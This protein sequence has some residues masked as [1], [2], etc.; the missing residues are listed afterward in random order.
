M[1]TIVVLTER[2]IKIFF[3]D[4]GTLFTSLLAPLILLV[5]FILFLGDVY[6]DSFLSCLP[7]GIAVT[8]KQANGFAGG[9]LISSLLAVCCVSVAFCA[10]MQMVQDK[11][12]GVI[13]D[14]TVAPYKKSAL[15]I[16]YF[17]ATAII[18]IAICYIALC[19]GLIYIAC[20]GWYLS[21][22]QVFSI[23]LDVL[24]LSTFGTAISSVICHFLKSQGGI[25]AVS[26]TVSSV[27]GFI[28][29]AY[30]PISQFAKAIQ[31]IVSFL[32]ATYGTGLLRTHFLSGVLESLNM[33]E[34]AIEG[35]RDA[36]DA[37]L[38]FFENQVSLGAMYAILCVALVVLVGV[39]VLLNVVRKKKS[40]K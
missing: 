3:K 24:L 22:G 20:V 9:F 1:K 7:E 4:K 35:V 10:N 8:E 17:L 38:Y 26:V 11:V 2:N 34:Q 33:P 31:T 5:L 29:G 16:S 15:S 32:P 25:T 19:V 30:M 21:V 27:Y 13:G 39:F 28:C 14:F 40:K 23:F 12:T 18:T 37:N 6:K 36:F